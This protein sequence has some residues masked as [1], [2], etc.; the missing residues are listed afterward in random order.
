MYFSIIYMEVSILVKGPLNGI[1][2][3]ELGYIVAGPFAGALLADLGAEV[4]KIERR[5]GDQTRSLPDMGDAI[6]VALNRGK[7]SIVIDLKKERGREIFLELAKRSQ[8]VIENMGPGVVD[9]LGIGF[10]DV[11][12]VNPEI[13]YVSIKGFGSGLYSERPALDVVA[14]AM[15]GLMSVTGIPGG[16]PIRVGTSIAD[17]L[18]GFMAV[19][20]IILSL[21]LKSIGAVRGP[22][23]IESPLLD[24]VMPLMTYWITYYSKFNHD[25]EPIGSGHKVWSPYR[26]FKARDGWVFIGVT[27]DKHWK[28]LCEALSLDN[29]AGD[30]RLATNAGRVKYRELVEK[31]VQEKISS[32][33][34]DEVVKM[35]SIRGVPVSPIYRVSDVVADKY[36]WDRGLIREIF[37]RGSRLLSAQTP[38]YI[39]GVSSSRSG[40]PPE[41]GEHTCSVL[42]DVLGYSDRDLDEL[43]RFGVIS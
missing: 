5:E 41:L 29:L 31:A 26:A 21:Y 36:F 20:Q 3:L 1:R 28:A 16:E 13:I 15:S 7:K 40:D 12:K 9:R 39:S 6:F 18:A 30:E 43:K 37:W 34:R 22:L 32:M 33:E 38:I 42:R 2:V 25:P 4:I 14:Q 27:S 19:F 24:S 35:L 10:K 17:M 11:S 8:V 23:F